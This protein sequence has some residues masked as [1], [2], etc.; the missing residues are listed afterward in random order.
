MNA[1][2]KN[3]LHWLAGFGIF[4]ILCVGIY[5]ASHSSLFYLKSVIV[6][7]LS[8]DYPI[9]KE[10]VLELAHVSTGRISLF[11]LHLEPIEARLVK[12]PWVKGVVLSKQFP[13]TL[14]LR[15]VERV[16]VALLTE[17]DGR[18]LYLD[19]DGSTFEDKAMV[20]PVDL[21]IFTGFPAQNIETLKRLNAFVQRW[22]SSEELPGVKL[23][24]LSYDEKLGLK[25]I[26][27]YTMRNQKQMRS[28][29]ELG[30][31]I[32]EA[33]QIPG[34]HLKRI[35]SYLGERSMPASKIWL[36]DGKKIVVKV[37]RG[38]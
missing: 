17:G 28:V 18:I 20:Y 4:A 6:E 16:P 23:S 14:S 33:E 7:P 12:N 3:A 27:T 1:K 30:L 38:S 34:S 9:T 2:T 22:F 5:Q 35:L 26:I 31:N 11:D 32:E 21:P 19:Q 29:L 24:S 13:S 8:T 37:S 36:G 15:V 25:A 10:Q